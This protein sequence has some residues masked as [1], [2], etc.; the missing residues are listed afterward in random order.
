MNNISIWAIN[1]YI[2]IKWYKNKCLKNI[3]YTSIRKYQMPMN[4]FNRK[5]EQDLHGKKHYVHGLEDST[6]SSNWSVDS[7]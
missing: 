5:D 1:F 4:Q 3:I 7:K 6:F 2:S